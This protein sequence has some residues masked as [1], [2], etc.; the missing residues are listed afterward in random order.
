M[1]RKFLGCTYDGGGG[2]DT[3]PSFLKDSGNIRYKMYYADIRFNLLLTTSQE[4]TY[5]IILSISIT[6]CLVGIMHIVK[7]FLIVTAVHLVVY[8]SLTVYNFVWYL[9]K[10]S[11]YS[12]TLHFIPCLCTFFPHSSQQR[13]IGIP[14]TMH[15]LYSIKPD[16]RQYT[17][18]N[19]RGA[20]EFRDLA[21]EEA[22]Y[23]TSGELQEIEL[24]RRV[25][26]K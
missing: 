19:L 20:W 15:V 1:P 10:H 12:G 14:P 4:S 24:L 9:A 16:L 22:V 2:W 6:K 26:G 23:N 11:R 8:H 25:T 5:G 21:L 13:C 3:G 7:E 17:T 18:N